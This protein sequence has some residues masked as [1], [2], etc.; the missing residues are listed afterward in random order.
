[1]SGLFAYICTRTTADPYIPPVTPDIRILARNVS[2]AFVGL[3]GGHF[4]VGTL[5]F[6]PIQRSVPFYLL[7]DGREVAKISFPE[8]YNYI[9]DTQGTPADPDNFVLPNYVGAAAFTPATAAQPETTAAGST[10][11]ATPTDPG[12]PATYDSSGTVDSG[13][14]KFHLPVE[15][16]P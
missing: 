13:G 6:Y 9:G 5:Q 14:A 3:S 1:M 16:P 2:D 4:V 11:S 15:A 10:T 12:L 7:C 8:L